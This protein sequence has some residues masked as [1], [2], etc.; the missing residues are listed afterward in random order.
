MAFKF[1]FQAFQRRGS[2]RPI[3]YLVEA[4]TTSDLLKGMKA[5]HKPAAWW[6]KNASTLLILASLT[7]ASKN[8]RRSWFG[9]LPRSMPL[10]LVSSFRF[11]EQVFFKWQWPLSDSSM[12]FMPR[13]LKRSFK[14]ACGAVINFLGCVSTPVED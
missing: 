6:H 11:R 9:H 5:S 4:T 10:P 7:Y 13:G 3:S 12:I 14:S 8:L 2:W 1:A